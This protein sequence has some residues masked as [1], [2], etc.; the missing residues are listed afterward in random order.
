MS[1]AL[2]VG[3]AVLVRKENR[4]FGDRA[5]TMGRDLPSWRSKAPSSKRMNRVAHGG[6]PTPELSGSLLVF[7]GLDGGGGFSAVTTQSSL[8]TAGN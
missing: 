7:T 6:F 5:G 1:Y 8:V 3:L 2:V 4:R